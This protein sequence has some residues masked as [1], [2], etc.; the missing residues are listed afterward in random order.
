MEQLLS[1]KD[2]SQTISLSF[3]GLSIVLQS[4]EKGKKKKPS[5]YHKFCNNRAVEG[6]NWYNFEMLGKS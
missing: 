3:K 4:F 6:C 5:S 1:W 2:K